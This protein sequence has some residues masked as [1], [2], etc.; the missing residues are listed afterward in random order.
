[1]F[2]P[3]PE[4]LMKLHRNPRTA[5]LLVSVVLS[6]GGSAPIV[7]AS[8]S[9]KIS[10]FSLSFFFNRQVCT[11]P[12]LL[13]EF[14]SNSSADGA[15][16]GG[17]GTAG[18]AADGAGRLSGLLSASGKL[19]LLHRLLAQLRAAGQRV[20]VLAQTPKVRCGGLGSML[21]TIIRTIWIELLVPVQVVMDNTICGN[22]INVCAHFGRPA[23]SPPLPC[24]LTLAARLPPTAAGAR[25]F[26]RRLCF[27]C[28]LKLAMRAPTHAPCLPPTPAGA[29][30][31][32]RVRAAGLRPGRRLPL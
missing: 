7:R 32:G 20:M 18:A 25:R 24:R 2:V 26:G 31:V 23:T 6:C 30:R 12:A 22:Q 10:N 27:P 1:M 21:S 9:L 3:D 16:G 11:H 8:A 28:L 15:P 17:E 13:P 5:L 19:S 14:E 29:G 4:S